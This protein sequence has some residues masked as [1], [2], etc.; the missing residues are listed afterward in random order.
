M[1]SEFY[2]NFN[3]SFNQK[4]VCMKKVKKWLG[5]AGLASLLLVPIGCGTCPEDKALMQ[6]A[7]KAAEEAKAAAAQCQNLQESLARIEAA[8]QRAEAAAQQAAMAAER[9][10]AAANRAAQAA[11][12]ADTAATK[13]ERVFEKSLRK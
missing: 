2:I 13:I 3:Q 11:A 1:L 10:D 7:I 6:E 4:E 5:I 12:K 8:A 9:A